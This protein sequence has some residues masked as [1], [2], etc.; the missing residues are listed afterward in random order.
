VNGKRSKTDIDVGNG[1]LDYEWALVYGDEL[2]WTM[3]LKIWIKKLKKIET[4]L[5]N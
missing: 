4:E 1:V 2:L 5:K 3:I